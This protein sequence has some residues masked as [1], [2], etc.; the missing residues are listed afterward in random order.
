MR[1][2]LIDLSSDNYLQQPQIFGGYAGEHNE[3]VLQ[4]VLPQRMI[5][6]EYS[7]YRFDFQTS[8]DNKIS[9]PPIPVSEL[10]HGVLSF[11]L[12][13]QL[14]IT[15]KLLFN[16]VG[17][18]LNEKTVSLTSKTNMVVLYI[19]NSPDGNNVLLDPTGYKDEMLA[20]IDARIEEINPANVSQTYDPESP[21]AQSGKA[22]AEAIKEVDKVYV[23]T[24]EMPEGYNI[25]I[26]PEGSAYEL[27]VTDQTY[28]PKSTNAQSGKAV[29][30]ALANA[31]V[32]QF[33]YYENLLDELVL[34]KG[35]ITPNG[36]IS[37]NA[38]DNNW[39][40]TP[41][42]YEVKQG[43]TFVYKVATYNVV[44]AI[45]FYGANKDLLA[46]YTQLVNNIETSYTVPEGSGIKYAR[47]SC[48]YVDAETFA[49][50]YI[51]GTIIGGARVEVDQTYNPESSNAQS[52]IAVAEA[53]SG[54]ADK[55]EWVLIDSATLEQDAPYSVTKNMHTNEPLSLKKFMILVWHEA[56]SGATNSSSIWLAAS[57]KSSNGYKLALQSQGYSCGVQSTHRFDG[58]MWYYWNI[59]AHAA[60]GH[61]SSPSTMAYTY[62]TVPYGCRDELKDYR[63]PITGLRLTFGTAGN[64]NA[65]T[66]IEVWGV[67]A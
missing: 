30:E 57:T 59:R 35:Y 56:K 44:S 25:Q 22:V 26:N 46:E 62:I 3:T 12:A 54:K 17:T 24:G 14:T 32:G 10:N 27:P 23:G 13:E 29:A 16:V 52:G 31:S 20:M 58:E 41:D 4:V 8:E 19:E 67:N 18:L 6:E 40:Y 50:Q 36:S 7:Y 34:E 11:K 21:L 45:T 2:V 64:L 49:S 15:G 60:Q 63:E 53:V 1:Y 47:F 5:G 39:R 66:R 51:R 37:G 48:R 28:N 61:Y 43:T 65:G 42:Y 9:S 38:T 55:E 33:K